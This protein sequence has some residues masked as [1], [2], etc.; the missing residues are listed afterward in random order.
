MDV[1]FWDFC[2]KC[3]FGYVTSSF[4]ILC[5]YI[6]AVKYYRL[7]CV[8]MCNFKFSGFRT[9][10]D[11]VAVCTGCYGGILAGFC[12]LGYVV[13]FWLGSL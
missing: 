4:L 11:R 7:I 1:V 5:S 10:N 6:C 3:S 12:N 9:I 13:G 8:E 2:G